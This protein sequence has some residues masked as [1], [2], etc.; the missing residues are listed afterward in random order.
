MVGCRRGAAP[1][2]DPDPA[3]TLLEGPRPSTSAIGF[4]ERLAVHGHRVAVIDEHGR[5]WTYTELDVRVEAMA[6]RLGPRRLTL[7][8]MRNDLDSIVAELAALRAGHAV[9]LSA[10]GAPADGIIAAHDPDTVVDGSEVHERRPTARH[11]LH[12]DLAMLLSTS[13]ST[14]SAAMTWSHL[15]HSEL[16]MR[17]AI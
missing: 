13:G 16:P 10:P 4:V 9:V 1:P 11:G 6:A 5:P 12:P 8:Q 2:L 7:V 3:M 14:G 17:R 15:G